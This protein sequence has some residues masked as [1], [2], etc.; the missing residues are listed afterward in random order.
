MS[1]E[2]LDETCFGCSRQIEHG[3]PRIHIGI[4]E[5]GAVNG[6]PAIGLGESDIRVPFCDDCTKPVEHGW[7]PVYEP[8]GA[9]E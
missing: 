3:E 2:T 9:I 4:D 1:D 7:I 5:W 6:L 8:L